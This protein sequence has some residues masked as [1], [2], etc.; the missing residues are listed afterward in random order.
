M[1]FSFAAV[2]IRPGISPARDKVLRSRER[3]HW[4]IRTTTIAAICSRYNVEINFWERKF[5]KEVSILKVR[6]KASFKRCH[7]VR[8]IF[9]FCAIDIVTRLLSTRS[10]CIDTRRSKSSQICLFY[11]SLDSHKTFNHQTLESF[12]RSSTFYEPWRSLTTD[13]VLFFLSSLS[14]SSVKTHNL[15]SPTANLRYTHVPYGSQRD[16]FRPTP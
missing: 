6:L 8:A 14:R 15:N 16:D 9:I 3:F 2:P 4:T 13:S 10:T 5:D 11:V 7:F 12:E 1:R